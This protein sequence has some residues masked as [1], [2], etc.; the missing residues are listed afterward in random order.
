MRFGRNDQVKGL[1]V[2]QCVDMHNVNGRHVLRIFGV[3]GRSDISVEDDLSKTSLYQ[4]RAEH[5][6]EQNSRLV[7]MRQFGNA[8]WPFFAN[9]IQ[10]QLHRR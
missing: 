10:S 3:T 6:I 9:L 7:N 5:D 1:D 4:A 2:R 8:N